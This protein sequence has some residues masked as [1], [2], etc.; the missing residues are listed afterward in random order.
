MNTASTLGEL[1]EQ[2]QVTPIVSN[3]R[4]FI[5][6]IPESVY[7]S[8]R[9]HSKHK[10][11]HALMSGI[12]YEHREKNPDTTSYACMSDG[13]LLHLLTMEPHEFDSRYCLAKTFSEDAR[14]VLFSDQDSLK[15]FISQHNNE[16]T[17]TL[18]NIKGAVDEYNNQLLASVP[19]KLD[20]ES[21][22]EAFQVAEVNNQKQNTLI[23]TFFQQYFE[24]ESEAQDRLEAVERILGRWNKDFPR[25]INTL[26]EQ[27]EGGDVNERA[28]IVAKIASEE[29]DKLSNLSKVEV[30]ALIP[31]SLTTLYFTAASK[32][33]AVSDYLTKRKSDARNDMIDTTA[34]P[35]E[36]VSAL[37]EAGVENVADLEAKFF[38]KI[39]NVG[40]KKSATEDYSLDDVLCCVSKLYGQVVYVPA[41]REQE[42]A[43]AEK[44]KMELVTPAQLSHG[45]RIVTAIQDNGDAGSIL[46]LEDNLYEVSMVWIDDQGLLWKARADILNLH[47]NVM[48]DLKFSNSAEFNKVAR[49]SSSLNYHLEDAIYRDGFNWIMELEDGAKLNAFY[50]VVVEKDASQLGKEAVKPVRVRVVEFEIEDIERGHTL[51]RLGALSIHNWLE[52]GSYDGFLGGIRRISVPAYQRKEE[53]R[54]IAMMEEN[55]KG[56]DLQ[57]TAL[58]A[59]DSVTQIATTGHDSENQSESTDE[60]QKTEPQRTAVELPLPELMFG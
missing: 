35:A 7:R 36:Q 51:A 3:E 22:P 33:K 16:V 4:G 47:V 56:F 9:A 37:I 45:N 59:G 43:H 29:R 44:N 15:K 40:N 54:L 14:Q 21:L 57:S 55:L 20:F 49:D 39:P 27:W 53:E 2:L 19:T 10:I 1:L 30:L 8:I 24:I 17:T 34:P 23:E 52:S 58:D 5:A 60:V 31:K 41:Y 18:S 32:R 12:D 48:A 11:D 42:K 13:S 46:S 50:F 38:E 6:K 25:L 26:L 28:Q